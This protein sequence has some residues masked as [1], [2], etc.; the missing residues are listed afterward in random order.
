[1]EI[2]ISSNV[3]TIDGNIKS[4]SDFQKIKQ[5][6]DQAIIQHNSIVINITNSLSITSSV[7][8][9]LN[10]LAL[11]DGINIQ[12]RVGNS[13]LL[14]L[15]EDLSLTATFNAKEFDFDN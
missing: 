13:Q 10:K 11:K 3:I 2:T 1:M 5:L 7:I 14:S 6:L 12:M 9:Y 8:G 4:V 15:L